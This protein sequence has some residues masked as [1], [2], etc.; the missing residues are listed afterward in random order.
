MMLSVRIRPGSGNS[1]LV[2]GAETSSSTSVACACTA[3]E[4]CLLGLQGEGRAVA[5]A[6]ELMLGEVLPPLLLAFKVRMH[7]ATNL[8]A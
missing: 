8:Q 5:A 7:L 6:Q 1:A 4:L 2:H 3:T